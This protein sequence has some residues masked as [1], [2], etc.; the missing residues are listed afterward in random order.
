MSLTLLYR[1]SMIALLGG[2]VVGLWGQGVFEPW[3]PGPT[4]QRAQVLEARLATVEE[5]LRLQSSALVQA[6]GKV[7]PLQ[8]AQAAEQDLAALEKT[9]ATQAAWPATAAQVQALNNRLLDLLKPLPPWA[10]D[11]LLPRLLPLKWS[12]HT[13]WILRSELPADRIE[14]VNFDAN[15]QA[16]QDQVPDAVVPLLRTALQQQ[17]GK[18]RE[19]LRAATLVEARQAIAAPK[20]AGSEE[21]RRL[22]KA[23]AL[24]GSLPGAE[25]DESRKLRKDLEALALA[26]AADKSLKE[27]QAQRALAGRAADA[28]L[29]EHALQQARQGLMDLRLRF[30]ALQPPPAG[31]LAAVAQRAAEETKAIDD[32]LRK[33]HADRVQRYQ[34]QALRAL[35][36]VKP[37]GT[38]DFGE[39]KKKALAAQLIALAWVDRGLLDPAVA[40]WFNTVYAEAFKQLDSPRKEQVVEAFA[41]TPKR[42][43]E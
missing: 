1:A 21:D 8:L 43:L 40:D 31:E 11:E 13:L 24:L 3:M 22:E 27:A 37:L 30:A 7:S 41:T 19:R 4:S 14:L 39:E 32:A 6:M 17:A 36:Q 28:A 16:H 5:A 2:A 9:V 15:L 23:A 10:Q 42:G 18:V 33:R 29:A 26:Q 25:D 38:M 35:K 12:I 34:S 20:P